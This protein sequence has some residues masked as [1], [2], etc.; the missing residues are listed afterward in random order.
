MCI[1]VISQQQQADEMLARIT[2]L[3]FEEALIQV[4]LAVFNAAQK[5]VGLPATCQWLNT[6][7]SRGSRE[8]L[9]H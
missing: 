5:G 1:N 9:I 8:P 2:S 7:T 6:G 4:G 3:V